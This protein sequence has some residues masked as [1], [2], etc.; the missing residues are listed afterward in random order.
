MNNIIL[1]QILG[2]LFGSARRQRRG[3]GGL[4]TGGL[5]GGLGGAALGGV[6]ASVL[7]G[8]G[9]RGAAANRGMLIALL[10]PFAMRWIERN[11]GIGAV[12]KRFQDKGYS[13]QARSWVAAGQNETLDPQSVDEVIGREELSRLSRQ[14]GV[15][16]AEVKQSFA[17]ILPEMVDQL[18]PDGRVDAEADEVLRDSIPVVERELRQAQSES[19]PT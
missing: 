16:E 8:R 14:L 11:G 15:D 12:L 13:R 10:L 6:L 3:G 1:A 2:G 17:E 7:R 18:T 4:G 5:G 19:T 9:A